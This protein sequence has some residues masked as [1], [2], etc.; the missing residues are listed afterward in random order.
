MDRRTIRHVAAAMAGI[1]SAIYLL[2]GLKVVAVIEQVADQPAFGLPAAIAFAA[3]AV[4]LV[5]VDNRVL[6]AVGAV[7]QALIILMYVGV[8]S[9]RTPP[10]EVW[11]LLVR[12]A[13]V[14]LFVALVILALRPTESRA[15]RPSA[16]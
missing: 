4:A 1:A 15:P 6:W 11:G 16:A 7:L 12:V 2:I 14:V 5:L 3:A 9:Q 8:A 10:F 13:Q